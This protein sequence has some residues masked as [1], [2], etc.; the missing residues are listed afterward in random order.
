LPKP[1]FIVLQTGTRT[2]ETRNIGS[3]D[4]P[5]RIAGELPAEIQIP[6]MLDLCR[7][8]NIYMKEHNTDY[9]SNEALA[10]HPKL[11]IH[12]ANVAPEFGVTESRALVEVLRS[13]G[14]SSLADDFL[15]LA[16]DSKKWN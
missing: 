13:N 1:M 2:M 8:F 6:R 16:Y 12:A 9:L 15:K 4:S 3:F 11:G 5:F 7:R 10:W 14:L